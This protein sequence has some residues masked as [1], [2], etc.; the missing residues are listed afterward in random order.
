MNLLR[1]AM[2]IVT[3]MAL[4]G[5]SPPAPY[6]EGQVWE[7]HNRPQDAGSLLK[8]Q[9]IEAYGDGKVYH[10]SI[11]GVHFGRPGM[12]DILPHI[13]VSAVTLDKSV[14]RLS[15]ANPDL[16]ATALQEGVAEWKKAKGGT[17][18]IPVSE[19]V[20]IVDTQTRQLQ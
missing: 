19:I 2:L 12:A 5:Q 15:T 13:P 17:F 9:K 1:T 4:S 14:T 18:T 10:L 8:I 11:T 16:S 7:Y 20:D 6:A 3:A